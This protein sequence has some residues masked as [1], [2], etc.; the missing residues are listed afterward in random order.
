ME[1][2]FSEIQMVAQQKIISNCLVLENGCW[3]WQKACCDQRGYAMVYFGGR[4]KTAHRVSYEAFKQK[5]PENLVIDHLCRN[6]ACVNP[7][8]LETV[9]AGENT[10]RGISRTIN[11]SKTHC[12]HGHEYTDRNTRYTKH[13]RGISRHCRACNLIHTH[14]RRGKI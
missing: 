10:R 5:I 3:Q 14:R 2:E 13:K 9:T 7:S 8:H 4:T 1:N 11:A 6:R 12:P